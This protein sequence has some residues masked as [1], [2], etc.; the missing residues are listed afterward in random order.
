MGMSMDDAAMI[1]PA[2]QMLTQAPVNSSAPLCE[3]AAST[4]ASTPS[5]TQE[6]QGL[7]D[8]A[9]TVADWTLLDLATRAPEGYRTPPLRAFSR[10]A[11][12]V[13]CTFLI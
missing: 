10:P 7:L 2:A 13:L 11:Q 1:A 6:T 3:C 9:T 4:E 5:V 8:L 12:S